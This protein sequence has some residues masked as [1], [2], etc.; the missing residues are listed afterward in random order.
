[1]ARRGRI[2]RD[3]DAAG[4]DAGAAYRNIANTMP[5]AT[6]FSADGVEAMHDAALTVLETN[7]MRVLHPGART[8]FA[9]AGA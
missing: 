8:I 5:R 2:R 9:D 4:A 3:S 1:M 7:G 6:P